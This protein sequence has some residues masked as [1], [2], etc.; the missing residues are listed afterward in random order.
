MRRLVPSNAPHAL[1]DAQLASVAEERV[2]RAVR[3]LIQ[4]PGRSYD[5]NGPSSRKK[6][7][8]YDL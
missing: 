2:R 7:L 4:R 3:S 6:D 8:G 5:A 1:F